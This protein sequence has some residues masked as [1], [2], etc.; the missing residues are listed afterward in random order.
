MKVKVTETGVFIP[1]HMLPDVEE[2]D[3]RAEGDVLLVVPLGI[4]EDPILGLGSAPVDC[5]PADASEAHDRYIYGG[6]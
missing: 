5:G 3:I 6:E 1:R 4:E 2:V